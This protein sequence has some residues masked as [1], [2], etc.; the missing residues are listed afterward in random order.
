MIN[1]NVHILWWQGWNLLPSKYYYNIKSIID[2]NPSY[3]IYKWDQYSI[4]EV[5]KSLGEQYL[6]KLDSF[7][8]LHQQID[9]S[10]FILLFVFGGI[11]TDVDV[12]AL[13]GFDNTPYIKDRD[14]IISYN[15]SNAL[16]NWVKSGR[17]VIFNNATILVSAKNPIIKGLIDHLLTVSC[18]ID[19]SKESCVNNTTGPKGFTEYLD[20]YKDQIT[21][22]DHEY[23]EPCMG[24]DSGCEINPNT[25]ILDHQHESSWVSPI[26]KQFS[27]AYY[28][29]KRNW[30][31][32]LAVVIIIILATYSC[33]KK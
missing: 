12:V 5:V 18:S 32:M 20:K 17:S 26:H 9:F 19:Q 11:S 7:T 3:K 29:T 21:I 25:S 6:Q 14:F 33:P 10:K 27:K 1:K 13:N 31:W 8:T 15:S 2:K 16:E 22:L 28:F 4:R 23:F 30:I 24:N